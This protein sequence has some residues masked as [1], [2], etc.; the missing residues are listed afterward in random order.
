LIAE[1]VIA[2][3]SKATVKDLGH[4][5][6]AHPTLSEAVYESAAMLRNASK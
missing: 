2:I 4:I 6:H 1:C 3:E 5:I